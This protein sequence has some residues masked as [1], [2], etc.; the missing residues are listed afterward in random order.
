[1]W[2]VG[3]NRGADLIGKLRALQDP[4]FASSKDCL[5]QLYGFLSILDVKATGMLTVNTLLIAILAFLASPEAFTRFLNVPYPKLV[6]EI[7]L[8][9]A[10]ISAFLCLL[11]VRMS[12][13]CLAEVPRAPSSPAHFED[14]LKRLA[15][16][17]EDRTLYY[18][19]A[20]LLALATFVLTLA[21]WSWWYAL[22]AGAVIVVW[23]K[24]RG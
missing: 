10:A 7:Q 21:W 24:A 22:I 12:W 18:W 1:M 6:L 8:I 19:V 17:I 2:F 16:V 9:L 11:V 20:W 14:E 5:A 13:R 23:A 15:N 4:S 3:K